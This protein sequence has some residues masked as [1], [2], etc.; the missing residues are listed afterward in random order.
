MK[1][2][3]SCLIPAAIAN[4][5]VIP[6]E[7]K[8]RVLDAFIDNMDRSLVGKVNRFLHITTN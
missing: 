5:D 7:G 1:T 6:V 2:G 3:N 4:Y 8:T